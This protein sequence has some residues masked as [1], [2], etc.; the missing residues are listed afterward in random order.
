MYSLEV[1]CLSAVK[2]MILGRMFALASH[3]SS[4]SARLGQA[5]RLLYAAVAA[6]NTLGI[7]CNIAAAEHE[8]K[9]ATGIDNTISDCRARGVAVSPCVYGR[10][11]AHSHGISPAEQMAAVRHVLRSLSFCNILRRYSC[12][13]KASRS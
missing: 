12:G 8:F 13:V 7:A 9:F 1:A 10:L 5:R 4:G 6:A 11:R 3:K 2:L